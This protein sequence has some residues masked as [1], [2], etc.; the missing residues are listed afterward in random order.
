V[1]ILAQGERSA[2]SVRGG[3]ATDLVGGEPALALGIAVLV[4]TAQLAVRRDLHIEVAFELACLRKVQSKDGDAAREQSAVRGAACES[5]SGP[6]ECT[7]R[8]SLLSSSQTLLPL[9]LTALPAAVELQ[10]G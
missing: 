10:Q 5:T 7:L 1:S 2:S 4:A 3:G 8:T 6:R 9:G